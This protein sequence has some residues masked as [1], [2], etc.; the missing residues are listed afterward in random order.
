[1]IGACVRRVAGQAVACKGEAAAVMTE[2]HHQNAPSWSK[3]DDI[4][5]ASSRVLRSASLA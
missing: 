4:E 1:M 3:A 5:L 2:G